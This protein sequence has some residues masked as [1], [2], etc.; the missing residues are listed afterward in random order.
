MSL[1]VLRVSEDDPHHAGFIRHYYAHIDIV[2]QGSDWVWKQK[3]I[4]GN[5][6]GNTS[7]PQPT[8]DA[9]KDDAMQ[10]FDGDEWV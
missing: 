1:H 4:N 5:Y 9:A 10:K 8:E 6:I 7:Q 2:M 3:D